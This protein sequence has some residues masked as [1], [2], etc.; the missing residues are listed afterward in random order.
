MDW[1]QKAEALASLNGG[2]EKAMGRAGNFG[3]SDE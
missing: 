1:Q 3:C 2:S